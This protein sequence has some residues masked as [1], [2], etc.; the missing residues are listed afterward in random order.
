MTTRFA[1]SENEL[2]DHRRADCDFP[3]SAFC[4]SL[5]ERSTRIKFGELFPVTKFPITRLTGG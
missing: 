4:H 5:L 2:I 1:A 3:Q